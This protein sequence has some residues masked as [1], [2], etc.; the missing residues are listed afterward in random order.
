MNSLPHS[1]DIECLNRQ[2]NMHKDYGEHKP[3][4]C[5]RNDVGLE[6][7]LE[8]WRECSMMHSMVLLQRRES[9]CGRIQSKTENSSCG[10]QKRLSPVYIQWTYIDDGGTR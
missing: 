1:D 10:L 2:T 6:V 3:I 5:S 4:Q 7:S 9:Q 8:A